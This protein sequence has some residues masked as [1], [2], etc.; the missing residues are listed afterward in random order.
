MRDDD[1][2]RWLKRRRDEAKDGL[3]TTREYDAIDELLDDYRAHA[4]YGLSLDAE[5]D[6]RH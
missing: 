1:V 2:D 4:D 6:G 3:F 5:T